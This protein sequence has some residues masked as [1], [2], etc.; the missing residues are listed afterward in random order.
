MVKLT[1][2]ASERGQAD[3]ENRPSVEVCSQIG[4]RSYVMNE[5]SLNEW[6]FSIAR[7]LRNRGR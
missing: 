4:R 7:L 2:T 6:S 5:L 1:F 3:S